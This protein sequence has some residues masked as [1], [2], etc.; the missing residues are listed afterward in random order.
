VDKPAIALTGIIFDVDG[1]LLELTSAEED[2]FFQ[3]FEELYG[4]I[5]LERDWDSY[6]VRN[7]EKIVGEILARHH[8]PPSEIARFR[9]HYLALLE[10]ALAERRLGCRAIEGIGHLLAALTGTARLGIATA[11]FLDAARLRLQAA[12]L[13]ETVAAHAFGA[14]GSGHKR[15]TL[16]SA[17]ADM[18]LPKSRIVYVGDNLNDLDAA[19]ANGVAFIGFSTDQARREKLKSAGAAHVSA[20]HAQTLTFVNALLDLDN[21]AKL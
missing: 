15:D 12:E 2:V 3:A 16:A 13:W 17:I 19:H 21:G 6:E 4:I 10:L 14:D 20:D 11:N 7:D 8:R 1:V 5:H 18:A 9:V